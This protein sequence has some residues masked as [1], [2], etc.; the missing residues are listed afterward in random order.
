VRNSI[1]AMRSLESGQIDVS[2]LVSHELPLEGFFDGVEMIE[3]GETG[4]M[5]ILMK[6]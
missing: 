1:Q 6:P 5:K 2:G 3:Q 4:V